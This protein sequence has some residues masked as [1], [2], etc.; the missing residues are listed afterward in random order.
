MS[1]AKIK[2]SLVDPRY[3]SQEN[4]YPVYRVD[5]W[6]EDRAC[7]ENRI[8]DAE[9][10]VEVLAWAEANR[11]GRYAV[12]WVEYIYEGGI[13][14]TRLHWWIPTEVGSPSANDPYFR[15]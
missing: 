9:S 12:I 6:D 13:G 2:A 4:P 1:A 8:E 7:Y 15:Q 11:H 14:M 10:I 3:V 5:F